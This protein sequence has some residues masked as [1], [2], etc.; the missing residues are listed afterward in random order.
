LL[1][2]LSVCLIIKN[3]EKHLSRCLASIKDIAGE[4]IIVDTGS[5]DNSLTIVREFSDKVYHYQWHNDF[6]AARNFC[7]GKAVGEWILIL[8]GDEIL[9]GNSRNRLMEIIQ[10][11]D[12]EA[13][14]LSVNNFSQKTHELLTTPTLQLRLFRNKKEYRYEGLIHEEIL[15]S[16][17]NYNPSARIEIAREIGITHYGY[18]EENHERLKRN[19]DLINSYPTGEEEDELL[20]NYYLGQ[21]YYHH[22]QFAK[23]LKYFEAIY[24]MA[25]P[26]TAYYPDLLCYIT[27]SLCLLDKKLEALTFVNDALKILPELGDLHFIKGIICKELDSYAESYQALKKALAFP[28]ATPYQTGF[29]CHHRDKTCHLLGS[30]AEYYLDKDNALFFYYESLKQNPRM[31]DSLR[32]MIAILNPRSYPEDTINSLHRIFD[33]SDASLQIDLA[34][35]FYKEGAYQLALDCINKTENHGPIPE[36]IRLLKGLCFLRNRQYDE[37]VAEFKSVNFNPT[38]Y[39]KSWQYLLLYYWVVENFG[40]AAESL[41]KIRNAG[42]DVSTIYVLN[43]LTGED[44]GEKAIVKEQTNHLAREIMELLI[45]LKLY[46]RVNDAFQKL[47]PVL[48]RRPSSLLGELFFNNGDYGLAE[49]EFRSLLAS[50]SGYPLIY[51]YLG[52]CCQARG[53]LMEARTYLLQA[54]DQGIDTPKLWREAARIHQELAIDFL[55]KGSKNSPVDLEPVDLIR[56][57]EET[58]LEL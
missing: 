25:D 8:D 11:P 29:F 31:L 22:H 52:K 32:R 48:G 12:I 34:R 5:T 2:P 37:A 47:A 6:S 58:L 20:R 46:D 7:L 38:V 28:P 23:A 4:I 16:I 17:L 21:E 44:A 55:K 51:Y 56:R 42:S 41:S 13:C 19:I 27:I 33:L 18:T 26:H 15:Q 39:V 14:L 54:I 30:L 3:E 1:T 43:L 45:E 57:L 10:A 36:D 49:Q 50:G 40:Q 35:I 53:D 24:N 9:G